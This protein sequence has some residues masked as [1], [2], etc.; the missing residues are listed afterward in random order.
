MQLLTMLLGAT[1]LAAITLAPA[2]AQQGDLN[3]IQRRYND[4][5]GV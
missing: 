2:A 3:S 4:L 1:L 5:K